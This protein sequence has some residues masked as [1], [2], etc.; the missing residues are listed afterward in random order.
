MRH[1]TLALLVAALTV[2][3]AT[4]KDTG[5]PQLADPTT[6]TEA[7]PTTAG[8]TT[9]TQPPEPTE[10]KIGD[11]VETGRGNFIT[12]HAFEQPVAPPQ[13]SEPS[14]GNEYAA[15][16]VEFCAAV[17]PPDDTGTNVYP[18]GPGDFELA[19]KDNTRRSFDI[20]IKEPAM[21]YTD[22]AV[23]D[24]LRGWITYQVPA[25]QR[26]ASLVILQT[27]PPIRFVL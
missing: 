18:V 16:D 22:V 10:F 25:G 14:A 11:R 12:L 15:A 4:E 6:T 7:P 19:M 5:Q 2:G 9:T 24:C 21:N 8:E 23:D 26:P 17:P 20:G 1:L 27:D 13:Y 3:C